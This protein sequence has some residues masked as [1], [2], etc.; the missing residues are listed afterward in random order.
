MLTYTLNPKAPVSKHR[1]LSSSFY[2]KIVWS[3]VWSFKNGLHKHLVPQLPK[4]IPFFRNYFIQLRVGSR[5]IPLCSVLRWRESTVRVMKD[6][7]DRK[8]GGWR[9]LSWTGPYQSCGPHSVRVTNNTGLMSAQ[10]LT[11]A[12]ITGIPTVQPKGIYSAWPAC[13]YPYKFYTRLWRTRREMA[14]SRDSQNA[15]PSHPIPSPSFILL[16][17]LHNTTLCDP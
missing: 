17:S 14:I 4:W 3:T 11:C 7:K 6:A 2:N 12:N 9:P 5:P 8:A 1:T 13:F 16:H 15:L 10:L